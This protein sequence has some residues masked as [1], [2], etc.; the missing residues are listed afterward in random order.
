MDIARK[1]I[2]TVFDENWKNIISKLQTLNAEN[3]CVISK[4]CQSRSDS[5]VQ[6]K[7]FNVKSK[8]QKFDKIT[9][10]LKFFS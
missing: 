2:E 3:R 5:K 7:T 4:V 6:R 1:L 9:I 8:F 10:S